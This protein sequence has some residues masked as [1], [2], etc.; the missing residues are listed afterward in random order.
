VIGNLTSQLL[1]NVYLDLLDRY[2]KY[3]LGYKY[4]G[5][6]VDDFWLVA[7]PE[8]LK[9]DVKRI[10]RYLDN[11][12]LKLHPKKMRLQP[13]E[14]GVAFLGAVVY[15]H[16]IL[17]G[18]RIRSGINRTAA[19]LVADDSGAWESLQSYLGQSKYFRSAKVWGRALKY[20]SLSGIAT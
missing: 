18:K 9:D 19:R 3:E 2:V 20:T 1:S 12:G 6:Y 5:R 16:R 8:K 13:A 14:R 11:I 15:P 17:P 7:E 4:Y 10:K